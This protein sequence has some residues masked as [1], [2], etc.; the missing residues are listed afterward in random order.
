VHNLYLTHMALEWAV[1]HGVTTAKECRVHNDFVDAEY[2]VV[3]W[4]CDGEYV[5][6]DKR[7]GRRF[8]EVLALRERIWPAPR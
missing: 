6:A 7:A 8:D 3:A 5:T 4:A 1:L 2:G